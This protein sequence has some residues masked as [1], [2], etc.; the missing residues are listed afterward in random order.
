MT[1]KNP[2]KELAIKEGR[3]FYIGSPHSCGSVIRYVTSG[4]CQYCCAKQGREKL[5]NGTIDKYHTPEKTKQRVDRWRK[6]NPERHAEQWRRTPKE[7]VNAKASKYRC[8]K[9]EQ[10]PDLTEQQKNDILEVYALARRLTEE[11]G[12][13]HE[14]DHIIPVSKGGLHHPD[15]LQVLT[16]YENCSKGNRIQ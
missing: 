9:R 2:D 3:K 4:T 16:K 10:T 6:N 7:K 14:V 1:K 12:I 13:K 8:S 5:Y 15:N 11:T